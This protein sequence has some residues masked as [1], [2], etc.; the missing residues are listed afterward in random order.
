MQEIKPIV[1]ITLDG[2]GER[3]KQGADNALTLGRT[4]T[5]REARDTVLFARLQASGEAV[6]LPEG[7][8]GNSRL[9]HS[10]IGAGRVVPQS[11]SDNPQ[12]GLVRAISEAGLSQIQI[13]ESRRIPHVTHFLNGGT[14]EI[15]QNCLEIPLPEE[16]TKKGISEEIGDA[17]LQ[18]ITEKS[19][20]FMVVNF[21]AADTAGHAGDIKATAKAVTS[22][23]T[24]IDRIVSALKKQGG[25]AL[26]VGTHGNVEMMHDFENRQRHTSHTTNPVTCFLAGCLPKDVEFIHKRGNLTD[27]APT[28][29]DLLELETPIGMTGKS[30]LAGNANDD[31]VCKMLQE[32]PQSHGGFHLRAERPAPRDREI[33]QAR[34]AQDLRGP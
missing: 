29:L 10:L 23:S 22:I 34:H 7:Q 9:G 20:H 8:P 24:Q 33:L 25:T 15:S 18:A 26:I 2:W 31:P 16:G 5:Y 4:K 13:A 11:D 17:A 27:V 1:L 14:E 28:L 21:A 12:Y 19:A 30:L 6:G 3:D 32:K